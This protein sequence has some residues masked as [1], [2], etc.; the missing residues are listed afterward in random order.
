MGGFSLD[1]AVGSFLQ[2]LSNSGLSQGQIGTLAGLQNDPA[3]WS[4]TYHMFTAA[5]N[6][7]NVQSA[8][9]DLFGDQKTQQQQQDQMATK[10][11][12][13]QMQSILDEYGLGSLAKWAYGLITQ[14]YSIN[15]VLL[16]MRDRPEFKERFPA[17][18]E[19][20]KAGLPPIS[21]ADY[22]R[23]E[24]SYDA[25]M[26]ESGLTSMFDRKQLYTKWISGDVSPTEAKDR[27]EDAYKAAMSEPLEVRQELTRLFGINAGPAAI[28]YFLDPHNALPK[29]NQLLQSGETAGASVR[30]GYGLLT[31]EEAQH[32]TQIGVNTQQAQQGFGTLAARHELFTALPGEAGYQGVSRESQLGAVFEDNAAARQQITRAGETRA[33]VFQGAGGYR[34]TRTGVG[35][36]G[37]TTT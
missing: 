14:G 29:L 9:T 23:L 31:A 10:D 32:L 35:G 37:G 24:K 26:H 1:P 2:S 34:T 27:A 22:V 5:I 4:D 21:P 13:A 28:S 25:Y 30:S 36:L 19:R 3:A 8:I 33:A 11:A 12:Q 7:P 6:K 20:K 15:Y 18:E 16:Q 17:I